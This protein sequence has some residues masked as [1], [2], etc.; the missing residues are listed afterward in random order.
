MPSSFSAPPSPIRLARKT[1]LQNGPVFGDQ[2]TRAKDLLRPPSKDASRSHRR[3]RVDSRLAA[4]ADEIGWHLRVALSQRGEAQMLLAHRAF[5]MGL[6]GDCRGFRGAVEE[7]FDHQPMFG[8]KWLAAG[9]PE[10]ERDQP[11]RCNH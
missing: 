4:L 7:Q 10:I 9:H 5:Q 11:V 6:E 2:I 1:L 3:L 8:E